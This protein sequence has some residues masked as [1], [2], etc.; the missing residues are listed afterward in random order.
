MD[1][2]DDRPIA[3]RR[4]RRKSCGVRVKSEPDTLPEMRTPKRSNCKRKARFSEPGLSSGLTPMLR[5]TALM[6]TP[7]SHRRSSAPVPRQHSATRSANTTINSDEPQPLRQI[8][9]GRVERRR[10]RSALRTAIDKLDTKYQRTASSAKAKIDNLQEQLRARDQEIHELQNATIIVDTSRVWDLERQ[11]DDLERELKQA[12]D[13]ERTVV[14]DWTMAARD[15]FEEPDEDEDMFGNETVAQLACSTPSR[16]AR[17]SFPTPP[18]TSPMAFAPDTPASVSRFRHAQTVQRTPPSHVGVQA[19]MPD[20]ELTARMEEVDSL[21]REVGKLTGTLDSYR[22]VVGKLNRRL[23]EDPS[24]EDV[25]VSSLDTIEAQVNSILQTLSD[26]TAALT[27][28][29][30]NIATLG[31]PGQN[32][33][34]ML[35]TLSAAFRSAR[36]ELEYLTPGEITLPLSSHGAEV[37]D[38]ILDQLRALAHKVK[39]SDETVDEY[40]AIELSLRQQLDARVTA[41]DGLRNEIAEAKEVAA[42]KDAEIATKDNQIRDLDIGNDRLRGA[43]DKYIRDISELERLIERMESDAN[44]A[45]STQLE[46][47]EMVKS[48]E[49]QLKETTQRATELQDELEVSQ[50]SHQKHLSAVNRRSGQALALRDARVA[51]LRTEID[52]VN[53]SLRQAHERIKDLRVERDTAEA[54]NDSLRGVVENMKAELQRVMRMSEDLTSERGD[55]GPDIPGKMMSG[56]LARRSSGRKRRRYDSGL[57]FLDED[58]VDV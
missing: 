50:A 12:Q 33:S 42:A 9:E 49:I 28:L 11:V 16:R 5:R 1:E 22:L 21:K 25:S 29:E 47:Q 20:P 24:G 58:E 57:G 56:K 45:N 19:S 8:L 30:S 53:A 36:L 13:Q 27:E 7:S 55:D 54:E 4:E 41:M 44:D 46:R 3:V 2:H 17:A 51:E 52:S 6:N 14:L 32:A 37:L 40:H 31:F 15:P 48:L 43:V 18:A 34:E 10:R 38:L 35:T 26:R 39:E 23:L